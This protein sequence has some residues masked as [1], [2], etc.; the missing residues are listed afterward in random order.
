M[1][2]AQNFYSLIKKEFNKH[3]PIEI[4]NEIPNK[5][6][7]G[8]VSEM[9]PCKLSSLSVF[10]RGNLEKSLTNPTSSRS[11]IPGFHDSANSRRIRFLR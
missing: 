1:K 3:K 6:F 9:T 2:I 5:K 8:Q 4:P 7:R 10:I 11:T